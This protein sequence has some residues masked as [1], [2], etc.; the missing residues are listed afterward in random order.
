MSARRSTAQGGTREAACVAGAAP[1][2]GARGAASRRT[3]GARRT[4]RTMIDSSPRPPVRSRA[5]RACGGLR[6]KWTAETR[7]PALVLLDSCSF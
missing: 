2:E 1:A 4:A 6:T 7:P 5:S 3:G